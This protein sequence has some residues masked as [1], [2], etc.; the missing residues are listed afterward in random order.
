MEDILI[1]EVPNK[2]KNQCVGVT[3]PFLYFAVIGRN[4]PLLDMNKNYQ[5]IEGFI[6]PTGETEHLPLP[7]ILKKDE[8]GQY[9]QNFAVGFIL[10]CHTSHTSGDG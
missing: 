7:D 9:T 4:R 3:S 2:R 1:W 5:I 8:N 6:G 10:C